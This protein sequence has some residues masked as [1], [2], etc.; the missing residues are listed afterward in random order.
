MCTLLI[1]IIDNLP[2]IVI[3]KCEDNEYDW[4]GDPIK[5]GVKEM[6]LELRRTQF[7]AKSICEEVATMRESDGE[8]WKLFDVD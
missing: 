1:R 8:L 4:D 5:P 7:E 2:L 6:T 3:E